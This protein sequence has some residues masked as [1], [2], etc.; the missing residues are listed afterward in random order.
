MADYVVMPKSDYQNTCDSIRAKTGKTELLKSSELSTEIDSIQGSGG[1]ESDSSFKDVIERTATNPTL[2]S[3]LTKIGAQAFYN[4]DKLALTSLPSGIKSIGS[5]AFGACSAL[6][7]ITFNGTPTSI[8][9]NAF[10]GCANLTQ[11][12]VPWAD[13]A[14]ANAPWGA[15]N[16][17]INYSYTGG[18]E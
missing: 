1:G 15:T 7:S 10:Y 8:A 14:V 2:P 13:G 5:Y 11:I 16:A 6:T 17:T 12:N 3:D 4:Y 9:T 18:T